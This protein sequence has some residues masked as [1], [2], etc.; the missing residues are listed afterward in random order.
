M[1]KIEIA[2]ELRE[3]A[4]NPARTDNEKRWL[5]AAADIVEKSSQCKCTLRQRVLGDG[6][7]HCNP[8]LA[9]EHELLS[10]QDERDELKAKVADLEVKN[11]CLGMELKD[12]REDEF[13]KVKDERDTLAARVAELEAE[14]IKDRRLWNTEASRCQDAIR[15]RDTLAAHVRE[16]REEI[17]QLHYSR[18]EER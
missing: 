1:N 14:A 11:E 4:C 15:E 9:I 16:L 13:Y 7:E 6:C 5:L 17:Q 2:K 18:W 10:A 3:M 8:V 12:D